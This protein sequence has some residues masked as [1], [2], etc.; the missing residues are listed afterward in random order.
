MAFYGHCPFCAREL[1]A[2]FPQPPEHLSDEDYDAW[3]DEH[4]DDAPDG[5]ECLHCGYRDPE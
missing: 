1:T 3:M 4:Q 5:V 2:T